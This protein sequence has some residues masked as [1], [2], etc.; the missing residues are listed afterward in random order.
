MRVRG[1]TLA[2][3]SFLLVAFDLS[4]LMAWSYLGF[5]VV[6]VFWL[7]L[8]RP[9]GATEPVADASSARGRRGG[10]R[11]RH[12][13]AGRPAPVWPWTAVPPVAGGPVL[14]QSDHLCLGRHEPHDPVRAFL[15]QGADAPRPC[16]GPV[17]APC[18]RLPHPRVQCARRRPA[19]R[20]R[21]QRA[22]RRQRA[23]APGG[24]RRPRRARR[25]DGSQHR[26]RPC[27][28][29]RHRARSGTDEARDHRPRHAPD[30]DLLSGA[31]RGQ[32][33]R[34]DRFLIYDSTLSTLYEVLRAPLPAAQTE[35]AA[36]VTPPPE[37]AGNPFRWTIV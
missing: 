26:D 31:G 6:A 3:V 11:V 37:L 15:L 20:H 4:R 28:P 23:V 25:G 9:A 32:H 30:R 27:G 7:T 5:V 21:A 22:R 8:V 19:A 16:P 35:F 14:D 17:P 33:Q 10:G 13:K 1:A 12:V 24:A 36:T 2:P 18:H 29:R 34:G